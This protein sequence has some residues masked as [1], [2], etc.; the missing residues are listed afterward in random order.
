M[1]PALHYF[2]WKIGDMSKKWTIHGFCSALVPSTAASLHFRRWWGKLWEVISS[3]VLCHGVLIFL[4]TKWVW[5][6]SH[7]SFTDLP[8]G[9]SIETSN[10][11]TVCTYLDTSTLSSTSFFSNSRMR[12][13]SASLTAL[14][15][16]SASSSLSICSTF[17][18]S[19]LILVSCGK[20][21]IRY[22]QDSF[23]L[24][25][26]LYLALE[27]EP[28]ARVNEAC[29]WTQPQPRHTTSRLLS[30]VV[31]LLS[32]RSETGTKW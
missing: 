12:C 6:L 18:A 13:L 16:L 23:T 20:V 9:R 11:W 26:L 28:R 25:I 22:P 31:S 10:D 15:T 30:T 27:L 4:K 24:W 8:K 5:I 14:L 2:S 17:W 1:T 7:L 3:S 19:R 32:L 21:T 29:Q